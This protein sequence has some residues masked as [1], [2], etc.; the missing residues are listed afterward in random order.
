VA[1][2]NLPAAF[3]GKS[4]R[5]ILQLVNTGVNCLGIKDKEG[6]YVVNPSQ[7]TIIDAKM[8]IIFFG[9]LEQISGL[10]RV[11]GRG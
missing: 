10:K 9:S 5:E 4:I 2:E 1:Y 8:K 11:V 6:K 7:E 3:R